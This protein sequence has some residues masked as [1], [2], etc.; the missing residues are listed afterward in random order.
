[1]KPAA[2]DEDSAW[3]AYKEKVTAMDEASGFTLWGV[4]RSVANAAGGYYVGAA[5]APDAAGKVKY[6]AM[7]AVLGSL[8]GPFALGLMGVA[9]LAKRND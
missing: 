7:G 1:M 8:I 4:V 6:G 5:M 3:E 9:A 2:G